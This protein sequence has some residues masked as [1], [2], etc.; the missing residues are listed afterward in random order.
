MEVQI[1]GLRES[2]LNLFQT[3]QYLCTEAVVI[4]LNKG[5]NGG[6]TESQSLAMAAPF[7][8]ALGQSG[9]ICGA[10]SGAVMAS[11][12]FLGQ[13]NTYRRR[14]EMRLVAGQLHEAFRTA[15]GSTCCRVLT[16]NVKDDRKAHFNQCA[17]LT[18]ES[19]ELAARLIL[20]E[21]SGLLKNANMSFLAKRSSR[22]G[23]AL[24]R[25][26]RYLAG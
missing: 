25:L 22:I 7:C 13:E 14:N 19:T 23:G 15:N 18:A 10:L 6:L 4:A 12:L 24:S 26:F 5:L 16:K 20:H 17:A 2:A 8:I 21:R 1:A 9:C 11:G 3:R